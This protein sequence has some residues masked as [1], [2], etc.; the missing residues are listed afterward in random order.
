MT[1]KETAAILTH[2]AFYA[3]WP[4]ACSAF[5]QA[6]EI[7]TQ[8]T[9]AQD[10]KA[11]HAA[12]MI[13]PIGAHNDAYAGFFIA[14]SYLAPLSTRQAGISNATLEPG[15]RN[16][17]HIRQAASGGAQILIFVA[18]RGFFQEWGKEAVEMNPGDVINNPAG[19]KHWHGAAPDSWF[20]HLALEVPEED[21]STM[22][23][24]PVADS[25][26]GILK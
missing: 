22:W 19:V 1:R 7:R 4:M 11:A 18:G 16:N 15:S 12:S 24:D 2:T 17:W 23:I 13:F 10:A 3:G 8:E 21:G 20:S 6:K 9:E 25:A 26:Y 14:N 5:S